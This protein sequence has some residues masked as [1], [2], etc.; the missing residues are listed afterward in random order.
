MVLI[1]YN[2]FLFSILNHDL[3][4]SLKNI[5]LMEAWVYCPGTDIL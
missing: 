3:K 4:K 5:E 1:Q 2:P